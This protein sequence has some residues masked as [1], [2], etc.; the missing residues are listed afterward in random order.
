MGQWGKHDSETMPKDEGE[1]HGRSRNFADTLR[2]NTGVC[3]H[4]RRGSA[5]VIT[6]IMKRTY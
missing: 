4:N 2:M 6:E 1:E 3:S 5:D